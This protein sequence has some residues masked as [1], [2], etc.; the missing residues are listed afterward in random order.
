MCRLLA[1]TG[2]LSLLLVFRPTRR[3]YLSGF[4]LAGMLVWGRAAWTQTA[5]FAGV[6]S[7]VATG[8]S[9][10][11]QMAVDSSGN[12]YIADD[13]NN[14]ILKEAPSG[15]GYKQ[16][17]VVS[18]G[19]NTPTAVAVDTSGNL[20]VVD[21]E[22]KRILKETPSGGS[23]AQTVLPIS[24]LSLPIDI[25][26]DASGDLYITDHGTANVWKE[27]LIGTNYTQSLV[28]GLGGPY[29]DGVAVDGSGNVYVCDTGSGQVLKMTPNGSG[30]STTYIGSLL[31]QPHGVAVDPSGVVYIADSGNNRIVREIPSGSSY[32]QS[33]VISAGSV[34]PQALALDSNQSLYFNDPTGGRI[35]ELAQGGVNF[36]SSAVGTSSAPISLVF[37]FD[38]G[39]AIAAPSVVTQGISGLDFVDA[40]S[41]TCT[42]NGPGYEYIA[43]SN[44]TL[45][46]RFSPTHAGARYGAGLLE[47]SSGSVI[48]TGYV[49]GTGVGPRLSFSSATVTQL[50]LP[51]V[52][53]PYAV[54]VDAAG[55]LYIAQ[56]IVAYDPSNALIKET[57]NGSGYT[58]STIVADLGYP[59]SVAVDGAG[60]VYVG[61]QDGLTVY[62]ETPTASGGYQ[63]SVVDNTLGT[64]GGLAVDASGNV[65]VGRGGI[66]IEKETL[67]A[68]GYVRS[69]IFPDAANSGFTVDSSGT[70]YLG[71]YRQGNFKEV[72]T[73]SGYTQT[74]ISVEGIQAVD[75][76]GNLFFGESG[77]VYE[78][79]LSGNNYVQTV[80]A[81]G[82]GGTGL[83]IDSSGNV[84]TPNDAYHYVLEITTSQAPV[85]HFAATA[86]GHTSTDSPQKVTIQ[87]SGNAAMNMPQPAQGYNPSIP[88]G[89]TVNDNVASACPLVDASSPSAGTLAA[90]AACNLTISFSPQLSTDTS[91]WLTYSYDVAGEAA[92]SY[93]TTSIPLIAG[94]AKLASII[95]W[96]NP[97]SIVYGTALGAQQLNASA[98]VPGTFSYSSAAGSILTVGSHTLLVTFTPTDSTDF[99]TATA[100]VTIN[101]TQATPQITWA[102]PTAITYGTALSS[103]QLTA[104]TPV[105]GTFTY[106]P[107][108]GAV[109]T[110]G[111]R[112]LSVNFTPTDTI[113]YTTATASVTLVVNQATPSIT[114]PTPASI[115]YGTAL[116]ATQLNASS[117]VSGTFSYAPSAGAVLAAGSHSLTATFNPT[118]TTDYTTATGLVY[119][120]VSQATPAITWSTPS[121]ITYGTALSS[122]QL[123]ATSPVAGTFSYSPPAGTV[124]TAG[125][126]ALSVTFSPTDTT[127]YSTA[128]ATVTL[129][130][131]KATPAITW[132]APSAIPYG[133][134]LGSIQLNATSPVAGKFAYSPVAGTVLTAGSQNLSVTFAPID[135]TDYGTANA[136]VTLTVNQ[137]T[138]P[139][140]WSA[141]SA[142]TYGTALSSAQLNAS[143]S[144]AGTFSYSP[145]VGTVLNAG[146]QT[147][148]ATFTPTDS[149]D[150]ATATATVQL[151]VNQAAPTITWATPSAIVFGAALGSAQLDATA[152]VP[153][154][155]V[156]N[157][158]S[159]TIPAIGSDTRR[160]RSRPSTPPTTPRPPQ[161]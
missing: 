60:N 143:S 65:Y 109:P 38:S 58:P 100:Q 64:V 47:N 59:T 138:P 40:G 144:V 27:T 149:T 7:V 94:G 82:V 114:W 21:A 121:P 105:A 129:T 63:Q 54:A 145:V 44:C 101:V 141:P 8:L 115:T 66:G 153:G 26:V 131:N 134:A 119:L 128:T 74:P 67:T 2:L 15:G 161:K 132:P 57:W 151:T 20:Y 76:F 137:V 136:T 91:G 70:V 13:S 77:S 46:V 117:T 56:A 159:G 28:V 78:A 43:G 12:V 107:A 9:N 36:G 31:S 48:A 84:Y 157:P 5:H 104:S 81:D 140:T 23:Y 106:T 80:L 22:N 150:Y 95:A 108:L 16:S 158:T 71:I 68:G 154:T 14:R 79:V 17:I 116:T 11:H 142:I 146:N 6:E 30:Y 51:N 103:T 97:P 148:K 24:G 18:S 33:V 3:L 98:N 112:T 10:P 61:D 96:A 147:L 73:G 75:G 118:D 126:Q 123:N 87:N 52:T 102:T 113:D 139:I 62:K 42:T 50:S 111:S 125:S 122:A 93:Q 29:L 99:T 160:S 37:T 4:L 88:S 90:G 124:L 49:L 127:D 72:P 152:S 69:D 41:G 92:S 86:V 32:N 85:L 1:S 39:G 53:N 135:T 133:T 19:L 25:A 35:L 155:F 45:D 130:V 120:T 34:E 55:N 83:A 156:Y 110:A 89:F